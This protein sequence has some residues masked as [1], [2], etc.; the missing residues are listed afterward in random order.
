MSNQTQ[1]SVP[2]DLNVSSL[3]FSKPEE[4]SIPGSNPPVKYNRIRISV[5]NSDRTIGD[6]VLET[7]ELLEK[8][9]KAFFT[10]RKFKGYDIEGAIHGERILVSIKEE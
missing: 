6:L 3:I 9:E 2:S 1:L 5:K 7:D 8:M 10:N 4:G